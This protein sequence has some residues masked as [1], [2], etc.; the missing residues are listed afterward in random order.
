MAQMTFDHM[1]CPHG[2]PLLKGQDNCLNVFSVEHDLC[3]KGRKKL[4]LEYVFKALCLLASFLASLLPSLESHAP[5]SSAVFSVVFLLGSQE[6]LVLVLVR[7]SL[8]LS[9]RY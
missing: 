2:D 8:N 6:I 3:P 7:A 5:R 1:A 9:D 4:P